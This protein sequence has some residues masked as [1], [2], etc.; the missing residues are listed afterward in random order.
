M[1]EFKLYYFALYARAEPARMML[2]HAGADWEDA[3]TAG[4]DWKA[5][6][7]NVP[8]GQ[9]PCLELADGTRMG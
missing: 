6:K 9:M 2:T 3:I 8:G 7:P 1:P 5:L 4:D